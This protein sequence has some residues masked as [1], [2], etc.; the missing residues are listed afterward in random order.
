VR[1]VDEPVRLT[2]SALTSLELCPARW[3]LEREAGG[4]SE[5]TQA[6]GFG[7]VVHEL[8]DRISRGDLPADAAGLDQLMA[9]VDAVWAQVPFRTPW[10]GAREREE[11]RRALTR[12]I[13]WHN[14]PGARTVLA[15]EHPFE[16]EVRLADG[17]L[18]RL[19]GYADR[20]ELDA[21]GRVVVVDL[22]TGKYPATDLARHPQLGLYQLAVDHG[23]VADLA[24][25]ASSGG[26][27][28]W[29]LR[30]D[31]RT[32]LKVQEQAPQ[33]PGPDGRTVV[34]EQLAAAVRAIRSERFEARPGGHCE[35]CSFRALCPTQVSGT[36]LH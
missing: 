19:H 36:V 4:A 25:D 20:L 34:E 24:G 6:Q 35:R 3:F 12:F 29:Q 10:S 33:Q 2:A 28:L 15:T 27:E 14:R 18:V 30:Q 17:E 7:N 22:K 9:E 8:A 31:S 5:A 23:A 32:G 13:A 26:A 1:P 11:V 21:D 16:A